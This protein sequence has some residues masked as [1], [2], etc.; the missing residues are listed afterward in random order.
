MHATNVLVLFS[1]VSTFHPVY[2]II[3]ESISNH[4]FFCYLVVI[5]K[6]THLA[7]QNKD[8]QL[9]S[10]TFLAARI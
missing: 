4:M 9:L 7:G 2:L 6:Q 8:V 5:H 1:F 10:H 3:S